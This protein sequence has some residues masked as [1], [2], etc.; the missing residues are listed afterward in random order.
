MLKLGHDITDVKD[1]TKMIEEFL[2]ILNSPSQFCNENSFPANESDDD[3]FDR[4]DNDN[5]K[6]KFKLIDLLLM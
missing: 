5:G 1:E 3:A 2:K 4:C 6:I